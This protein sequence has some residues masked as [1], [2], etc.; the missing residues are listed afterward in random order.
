VTV[1]K[2]IRIQAW[3]GDEKTFLDQGYD[4]VVSNEHSRPYAVPK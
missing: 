1:N 4:D 2:D 3:L